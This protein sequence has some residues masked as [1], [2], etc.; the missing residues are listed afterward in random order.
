M[1]THSD[2]MYVEICSECEE[3]EAIEEDL[4]E[5]CHT[6]C[7]EMWEAEH[8]HQKREYMDMRL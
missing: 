7:M 2:E 3:A 4:C 6:R 8:R 1:I 5:E